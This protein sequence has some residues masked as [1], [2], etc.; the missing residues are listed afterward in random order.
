MLALLTM[1]HTSLGTRI[2]HEAKGCCDSECYLCPLSFHGA[3][4]VEDLLPLSIER[5]S[6]LVM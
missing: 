1:A 3:R 5:H 2:N 6:S 4:A